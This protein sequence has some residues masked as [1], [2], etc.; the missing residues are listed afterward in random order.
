MNFGFLLMQLYRGSLFIKRSI[1]LSSR[2]K[3]IAIEEKTTENIFFLQKKKI[4]YENL[5][6]M[7]A[8][9]EKQLKCFQKTIN[10]I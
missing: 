8:L 2:P 4:Y 6:L 7:F 10:L 9:D 1:R 5:T 3:I